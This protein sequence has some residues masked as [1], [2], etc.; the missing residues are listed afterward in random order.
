MACCIF[1]LSKK[2]GLNY[3][4]RRYLF[5]LWEL[6]VKFVE[7]FERLRKLWAGLDHCENVEVAG[8]ARRRESNL[9]ELSGLS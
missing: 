6:G 9:R 3:E 1:Q 5:S 2:K 4:K 7:R 8:P